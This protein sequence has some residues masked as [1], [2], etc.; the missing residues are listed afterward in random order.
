MA[1]RAQ[2]VGGVLVIDA[3][4]IF[5]SM[6]GAAGPPAM[7]ERQTAI[8]LLGI[9]EGMRKRS[10]ILRWCHGDANLSDGLTKETAKTHLD[11]FYHEGSVW[12]LVQDEEVVSARKR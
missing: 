4:A 11:R 7:E 2:R 5:G 6:Y 3:E 1:E 9:Q 10:V 12:S 8:E